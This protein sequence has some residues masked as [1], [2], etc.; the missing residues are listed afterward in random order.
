MCEE[1]MKL[2]IFQNN[3]SLIALIARD[4]KVSSTTFTENFSGKKG[5]KQK[6]GHTVSLH[7]A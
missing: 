3:P 5:V 4:L 1:T 7:L 6:L 2:E